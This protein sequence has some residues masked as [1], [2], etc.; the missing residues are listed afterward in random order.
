VA[1]TALDSADDRER[2]LACG[3][4]RYE[5]KFDREGFLHTVAELLGSPEPLHQTGGE[6][7]EQ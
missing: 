1:L 3:F 6:M 2:A 4:N 7:F 5:V